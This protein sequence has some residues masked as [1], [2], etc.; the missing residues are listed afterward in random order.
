MSSALG[1]RTF[2]IPCFEELPNEVLEPSAW[3]QIDIYVA[4]W[5]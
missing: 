2:Q 1:G 5:I 4:V 3:R